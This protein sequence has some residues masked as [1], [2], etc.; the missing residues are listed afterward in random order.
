MKKQLLLLAGMALSSLVFGQL[1]YPNGQQGDATA[2]VRP[3]WTTNFED[4]VSTYP[5]DGSVT[6]TNTNNVLKITF[7]TITGALPNRVYQFRT[8]DLGATGN[9]DIIDISAHKIVYLKMKGKIGDL[10]TVN[11]KDVDDGYISGYDL[12]QPLT[13]S[14]PRWYKYDFSSSGKNLYSVNE[15]EIGSNPKV[16]TFTEIEI[17][18]IILGDYKT[19]NMPLVPSTANKLHIFDLSNLYYKEPKKFDDDSGDLIVNPETQNH[20]Y[21]ENGIIVANERAGN[22]PDL[23]FQLTVYNAALIDISA[24]KTV[25]IRLKGEKGDTI[26]LN[27]KYSSNYTFLDGWNLNQIIPDNEYNDYIFDFS[28]VVNSAYDYS[29]I[30]QV[31]FNINPTKSENKT[32]YIK[33][34]QIG[35]DIC[36]DRL[37]AIALGVSKKTQDLSAL[38]SVFP[39]PSTGVVNIETSLSGTLNLSIFDA[40]G[41]LV[42]TQKTQNGDQIKNLASGLYIFEIS[43]ENGLATTKVVVK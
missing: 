14:E 12:A 11:I 6:A 27:L 1:Y 3:M 23:A 8:F 22:S 15:I 18:S 26:R 35:D 16:L 41:Q 5:K 25:K 13:C 24:K 43:N 40:A 37:N 34:L 28:T 30:I 17:D 42:A 19:I 7:D 2:F 38:V 31:M 32:V 9:S 36:A 29:K 4:Y 20:M 21:S 10:V 39:N 33:S